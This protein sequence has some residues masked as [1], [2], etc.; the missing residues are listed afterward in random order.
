MK[1]DLQMHLD[2]GGYPIRVMRGG[3]NSAGALFRLDRRVLVVSEPG[4]PQEYAKAILAQCKEGVLCLLDGGEEGKNMEGIVRC[5]SAM[6]EAGFTRADCVVAVGG[7]VVGDMAGFAAAI[8]MRGIDFYNLPTTLLSQIDSSIGGKTGINFDGVKNAV[9]A[10]HQPRAVLIDPALLQTLPSRQMANGM[11]EA[12]KMAMTFDGKLIE[13][14]EQGE[15][16]S[17]LDEVILASLR[18]KQAVV[19][20]DEKETGLRRVLNFGHTVGHGIEALGLGLYHGEC[21]ALGMLAM[22][23]DEVRERLGALLRRAGLPTA[24]PAG[25]RDAEAILDLVMHDKKRAGD[26]V[27]TVQVDRVGSFDMKLL[28]REEIGTRIKEAFGI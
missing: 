9:G 27:M 5:L 21:V 6:M 11:A 10:F 26:G 4:V 20:Q 15:L 18:M 2:N 14:M 3:L 1:M 12:I 7:G 8:Y 22:C 16:S 24:L 19:E 23:G 13:A 17:M 28:T 25:A